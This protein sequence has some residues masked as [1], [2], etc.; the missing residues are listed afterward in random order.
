MSKIIFF[1]A[2]AAFFGCKTQPTLA[3][4]NSLTTVYSMT[5][6][7]QAAL[8]S[9]GYGYDSGFKASSSKVG[10]E[11]PQSNGG[12]IVLDAINPIIERTVEEKWKDQ[13]SDCTLNS[14]S[15]ALESRPL[16]FSNFYFVKFSHPVFDCPVTEGFIRKTNVEMSSSQQNTS[17]N[18]AAQDISSQPSGSNVDQGVIVIKNSTVC[19]FSWEERPG[20]TDYTLYDSYLGR[21]YSKPDRS[22]ASSLQG[23]NILRAGNTVDT[24]CYNG[25]LLKGCFARAMQKAGADSL[26]TAFFTWAKNRGVDPTRLKMA[27]AMQE[28]NLGGLSDSCA[29]GSCNGIGMN[30]VITIVTDSGETTNSSDRPEWTGITHNVLTNMKYGIRVLASKIR[31]NNPAD[32]RS[33]A[34][35]YN[36]SST[37]AAYA[38]A[39]ARNY[40][41]L[42]SKCGL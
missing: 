26:S 23:S 22:A 21:N 14:G 20:T 33:L 24:M 15:Y 12:A 8:I 39:V 9:S 5:I 19:E 2:V 36:G 17:Q 28:T 6:S 18:R 27:I 4:S 13:K 29:G 11:D 32:I 30:Q 7:D 38:E 34:R 40:S 35:A 1:A 41:E 16:V 37:A 42:Q 10:S 25:K 31:S 3:N